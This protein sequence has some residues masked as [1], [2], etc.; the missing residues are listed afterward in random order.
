MDDFLK[1]KMIFAIGFLTVLITFGPMAIRELSW[2]HIEFINKEIALE[3]VYYLI[4]ITLF[5]SI[6]SYAFLFIKCGKFKV[7]RRIGDVFY[8]LFLIVP[9]LYMSIYLINN[10]FL[11]I[12]TS[13]TSEMWTIIFSLLII[14]SFIVV[15]IK[16]S[17][18]LKIILQ[19]VSAKSLNEILK[20]KNPTMQFLYKFLKRIIDLIISS[21]ILILTLPMTFIST[22]ALMV[23]TRG[24]I[25]YLTSRVGLNG[26]SF[27]LI[28]F[29]TVSIAPPQSTS[30]IKITNPPKVTKLGKFLRRT[31]IDEIPTILNVL[32]GDLSIIGPRHILPYEWHHLSPEQRSAWNAKP[33]LIGLSTLYLNSL[34]FHFQSSIKFDCYYS[35]KQ[36]LILDIMILIASCNRIFFYFG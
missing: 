26:E 34:S 17:N 5:L 33:G 25:F 8:L 4:I 9:I 19:M 14:I 2:M 27:K 23:E 31:Y 3:K 20:L 32:K 30:D 1:T 21:I 18:R 24:S 6:F 15:T 36:S 11:M 16:I 12:S 28:K 35:R 10:A 22:I 29:K 7:F 13:L